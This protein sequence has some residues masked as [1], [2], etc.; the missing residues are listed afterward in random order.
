MKVLFS[1][2]CAALCLMFWMESA[3]LA[4]ATAAPTPLAQATTACKK[5]FSS[6]WKAGVIKGVVTSPTYAW[7]SVADTNT[8]NEFLF[9]LEKG[10]YVLIASG[11][12]MFDSVADFESDGV[13]ASEA[14]TLWTERN[15]EYP[16]S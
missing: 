9:K 1:I 3:T 11:K 4:K 10:S 5:S 2:G 16:N 15:A 6:W 7:C 12:P 13:P 8:G 14:R